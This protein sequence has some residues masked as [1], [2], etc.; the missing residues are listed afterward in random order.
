MRFT[1]YSN[2]PGS[3]SSKSLRPN[4]KRSLGRCEQAEVREVRVAAELHLEPR[5]RRV[6]QVRGH[7]LRRAS[8]E[9]E[10]RD[11][12]PPV[13]HGHQIGL[14]RVAFCSSSNA[15]GS[16]RSGGRHPVRR[17]CSAAAVSRAAFPRAFRSSTLGC[18]TLRHDVLLCGARSCLRLCVR[19]TAGLARAWRNRCEPTIRIRHEPRDGTDRTSAE[20]G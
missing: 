19:R 17:D 9:R 6:L 7:D 12:H 2:G 3:V 1:S 20:S 5:P 18:T 14:A 4:S 16:G 15:T 13:T 10:R 11:H 8:V